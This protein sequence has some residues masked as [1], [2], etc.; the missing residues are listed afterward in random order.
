VTLPLKG[1]ESAGPI[2]S[3]GA[4]AALLGL[5]HRAL[6][7]AEVAPDALL[8][9]LAGDLE[10]PELA[11]L[12]AVALACCWAVV[13]KRQAALRSIQLYA[14]AFGILLTQ[15]RLGAEVRKIDPRVVLGTLSG[16]ATLYSCYLCLLAYAALWIRRLAHRVDSEDRIQD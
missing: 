9:K 15:Y 14:L 6:R 2:T 13:T 1:R 10:A 11:M 7:S 16:V 3:L 5:I 8:V 4:A 12:F